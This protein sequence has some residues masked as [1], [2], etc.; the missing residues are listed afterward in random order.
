MNLVLGIKLLVLLVVGL[1]VGLRHW[2]FLHSSVLS[3]G[4]FF[5]LIL[6]G[7]CLWGLVFSFDFFVFSCLVFNLV[8]ALLLFLLPVIPTAAVAPD[9]YNKNCLYESVT[10]KNARNTAPPLSEIPFT[11]NLDNLGEG[12]TVKPCYCCGRFW[13]IWRSK[14]EFCGHRCPP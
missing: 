1:V 3:F 9:I 14:M 4:L 11:Q 10:S 7:S 13:V 8:F 12:R 5:G 6:L 2:S